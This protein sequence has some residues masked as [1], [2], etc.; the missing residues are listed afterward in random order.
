MEIAALARKL[1]DTNYRWNTDV[2]AITVRAINLVP[3][4]TPQQL[5]LF[6]DAAKRDKR[7]RLDDAIEEIRGRFGKWAVYPAALMGI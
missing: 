2:R 3:K 7:D 1:F 5:M 6:D 4:S